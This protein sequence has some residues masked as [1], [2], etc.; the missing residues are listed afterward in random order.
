MAGDWIKMRNN[1]WDDPRV[2]SLCDLTGLPEAMVIGGLYWLWASADEHSEDG[3]MPG[4][5]VTG[6]DRK[7]GCKGLG[8][9]LLSIGW[10]E[11]TP[12]GITLLRFD[13]HN[14]KSAKR[15]CLDAQRKANDRNP[16]ACDADIERTDDG[17]KAD[18]CGAREEKRREEINTSPDGEERPR[19]RVAAMPCPDDVDPQVWADWL[20]LRKAKRA[21]VTATAVEG[22]REEAAK[23]GVS[24]EA[25]LRIWCRRGSQG[26]EASW[27]TTEEKAR[28]SP[29]A[30][31]AYQRSMRNRV[32]EFAPAVA[33]KA[34]G[35][36]TDLPFAE[37]INVTPRLVG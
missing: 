7:T 12:G 14:G 27:L 13:E 29:L 37:V 3:R 35:K 10:I 1:L 16:S 33:A 32:S 18:D 36:T 19:K 5:S 28:D 6:I 34:P 23:A 26:L 11:D 22:A 31:T 21:T 9:G 17:Q 24:F 4:L 8:A 15:R 25:F 30:E 2:S 20:Q